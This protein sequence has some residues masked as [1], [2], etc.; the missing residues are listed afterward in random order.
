MGRSVRVSYAFTAEDRIIESLLK[1]LITYEGFYV[2]VGCNDP[3]FIS[4]TFLLYRRGWKGICVDANEKLIA[5]HKKIRPR[6]KAICALVSNEKK[7]MDFV[8]L[9]NNVLS[10]AENKYLHEMRQQGQQIV[11]KKRM[12]TRS[13]TEILDECH[14]PSSFDL[15]SVDAEEFDLM[16]LQSLDFNRYIPKLIVAEAEDFEA[17][18]PTV[19]P[20]YIFL[21]GKGYKLTGSILTNLYFTKI[22][23]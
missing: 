16:V 3:R 7:E 2:D 4:N 17:N 10:S 15:L 22:N 6:D 13:L 14:A 12:T 11:D 8:T 5:K 21:T 23:S 19:H 18:N 9:T 20:M 1:P